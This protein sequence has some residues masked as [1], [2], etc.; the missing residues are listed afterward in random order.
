MRSRSNDVNADHDNHDSFDTVVNCGRLNFDSFYCFIVFIVEH[1]VVGPPLE[2]YPKLTD[3]IINTY[4]T[5]SPANFA[6]S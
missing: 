4:L 2:Q 5:L 6:C 1:I 3:N